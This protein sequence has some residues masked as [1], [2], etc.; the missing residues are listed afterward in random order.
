MGY[1]SNTKKRYWIA[2]FHSLIPAY[3]IERL[4]WQQ[5]GMSVQMVVYAE[6]IYAL[7]VTV[8]EIPSGIL[9]DRFGRKRL[10]TISGAL[11]A[12]ELVILLYA[13]TF[14]HFAIAIFLAGIGKALSSGS[15]NALL[16]D[17]LLAEGK[18]S[19]FEKV[20]GRISA[21]DF[22]GSML[23]ALCGGILA[24]VF[25][26]EFNYLVSV[27]SMCTAFIITLT[28][29]EPPILTKPENEISGI[30]HYAKQ[31][32]SVF[33]S[34]PL[35][36]LYCLTGAVLGACMIYL[37]EFWQIIME[38]IGIPVVF[39]GVVSA[40]GSILRIPGNLLAYKLKE[41]FTFRHIL[42][43]IISVSIA[44]YAAI[45]FLR[46]LFC[47]VPIMLL[48]LVSGVVDPLIIGYLHN[49]TESNVRATV[50]SFSSLGMRAVSVGVG[51]LFGYICKSYSIFSG[52]MVLAA[53]C[54][55]YLVI[56]G[57]GSR[58]NQVTAD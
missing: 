52:F 49:H 34:Q 40:L 33:R 15:E 31:A 17:S 19:E 11:S 55:G 48:F 32:L 16:F 7:T 8:C 53:V 51:L 27:F 36:L 5:R 2:L 24:N 23:A 18:Q 46:D 50:E 30:K 37:D 26:F 12:A 41:N 42:T 56:F 21:I 57:V 6:I 9:A 39:F 45:F 44:G 1:L 4:F 13:H 29:R 10:L 14:W 38:N 3:V 47:L 43:C 22:S 58:K 54:F 28:L 20:L 25:S 35:V